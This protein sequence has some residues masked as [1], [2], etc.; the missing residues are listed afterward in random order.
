VLISSSV[1]HVGSLTLDDHSTFAVGTDGVSGYGQ[2]QA[3]GA[4]ILGGTLDAALPGFM[5]TVGQQLAIIRS[6]QALRKPFTV[7]YSGD[8]DFDASTSSPVVPTR[9]SLKTSARLLSAFVQA[10]KVAGRGDVIRVLSRATV[11]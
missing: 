2:V 6:N 4:V 1:L 5:N 8:G 10:G 11:S 7:E 9:K 3:S